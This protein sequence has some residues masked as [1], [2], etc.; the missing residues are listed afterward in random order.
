MKHFLIKVIA[1]I[2]CPRERDGRIE[3]SGIGTAVNRAIKDYRKEFK[4][5]RIETMTIKV[6]RLD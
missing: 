3:A 4:G 5:K 6:Q 2:P 1:D